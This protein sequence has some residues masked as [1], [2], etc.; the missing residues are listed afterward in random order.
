LA[1][2]GANTVWISPSATAY[3]CLCEQCLEAARVRGDLFS[4]ALS[5]ATVRGTLELQA[6]VTSIRCTA[7]HELLLRRV[8]RPPSLASHDDRQLSIA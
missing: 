8:E 3:A 4:D 2:T 5:S 1:G 6:L 7:G